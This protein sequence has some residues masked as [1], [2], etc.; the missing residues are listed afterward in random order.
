MKKR[1]Y[2][3]SIL[4]LALFFIP[5]SLFAEVKLP[6]IFSDHGLRI[7]LKEI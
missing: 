1:F 7:I 2:Q 3:L 6:S 5:V 4:I